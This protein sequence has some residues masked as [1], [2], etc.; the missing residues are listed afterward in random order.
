MDC[1]AVED[2]V[3]AEALELALDSLALATAT[4]SVA[5]A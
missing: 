2:I 4:H 1:A 3:I 5:A